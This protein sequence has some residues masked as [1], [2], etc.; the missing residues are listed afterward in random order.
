LNSQGRE[1]VG[2]RFSVILEAEGPALSEIIS[3]SHLRRFSGIQPTKPRPYGRG[4]SMA[5]LRA[6]VLAA[7]D[8]L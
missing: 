6:S 5:A 3:M 8:Y 7:V 4:Y 1:A 2:M